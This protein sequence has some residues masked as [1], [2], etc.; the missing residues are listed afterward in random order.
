MR[1]LIC[2]VVLILAGA[3]NAAGTGSMN[4]VQT[5]PEGSMGLTALCQNCFPMAAPP[6]A[7]RDQQLIRR[8][9][10]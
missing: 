5:K 10:G 8:W 6:V 4:E 3:A 2:S 9:S 7:S 1:V